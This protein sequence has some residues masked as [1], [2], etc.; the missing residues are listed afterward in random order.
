MCSILLLGTIREANGQSAGWHPAFSEGS[1]VEKV[2]GELRRIA[3]RLLTGE[4]RRVTET[5]GASP[6]SFNAGWDGHANVSPGRAA[7]VARA[8]IAQRVGDDCAAIVVGRVVGADEADCDIEARI[9]GGVAC[10]NPC[11]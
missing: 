9:A 8:D 5:R 3:E 1:K 11:R 2:G 6:R 7:P 4:R 10:E